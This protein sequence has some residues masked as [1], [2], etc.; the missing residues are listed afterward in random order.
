MNLR[1]ISKIIPLLLS[2]TIASIAS[3]DRSF[4]VEVTGS[5]RPIIFIPGLACDGSVWNEAVS[6]Y[7]GSNECHVLS[8]AGFA[9]TAPLADTSNFLE[10]VK[11]D[12]AAYIREQNLN[13]AIIVG[14]SLGGFL[15]LSLASEQPNLASHLL[16]VDSL[17][18][19]PAAM[20][21]HATVDSM[22]PQADAQRR[23]M[24]QSGQNEAQ[25]RMMLQ[26]MVTSSE[27][28]ERA[29]KLSASSHGPTVAQA[30]FELNTTDLRETVSNIKTPTTVLGAWYG[31]S[32]FGST[33]ESTAAI[34]DSQYAKHPNYRLVMSEKGKHFI[35]WDDPDL[36][37]Q[38]LDTIL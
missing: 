28:I 3:A 13:S 29:I 27:N 37:Y 38:E 24:S 36:F 31:Y 18:F 21:P 17:P 14:H 15:A 19:L 9:K 25:L 34:F 12:L 7:S 26:M 22:K 5:G 20:N 35:M 30:M 23:M 11:S 2:L 8:I 32:Q 6:Q 33:K 16:I 1:R 4:Q 10:T